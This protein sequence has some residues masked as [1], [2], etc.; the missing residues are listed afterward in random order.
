MQSKAL[1]ANV[2]V[3]TKV[4][5]HTSGCEF[6][7]QKKGGQALL[8]GLDCLVHRNFF[9]SQIHS[10]EADIPAPA[11]LPKAGPCTGSFKAVFIRAPAVMS[12]GKG[13]EIIAEY[14]LTEEEKAVSVSSIPPSLELKFDNAAGKRSRWCV[15]IIPRPFADSRILNWG[16][17]YM[18][19]FL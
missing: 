7:G 5:L 11:C 9:G 14:H 8:G 6:A 10:F 2:P 19:A 3:S 15:K 13:V 4:G 12:V 18:Q 17:L 16:E 1:T